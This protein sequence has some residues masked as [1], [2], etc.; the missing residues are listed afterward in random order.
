MWK[1]TGRT[2]IVCLSLPDGQYVLVANEGEPDEYCLTD[3]EGEPEESVSVINL[4][5][6]LPK[7]AF[8]FFLQIWVALEIKFA[9]N[10]PC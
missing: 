8:L 1:I 2:L 7:R 5:G 10:L 3:E 9:Y 6:A 4:I